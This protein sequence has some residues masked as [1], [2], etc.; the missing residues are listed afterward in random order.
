MV[1]HMDQQYYEQARERT[2]TLRTFFKFVWGFSWGVKKQPVTG[3]HD[4]KVRFSRPDD[5]RTRSRRVYRV[6]SGEKVLF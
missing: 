1:I 3:H 2:L 5:F 4:D 6:Q